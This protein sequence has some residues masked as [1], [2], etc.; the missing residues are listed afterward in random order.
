MSEDYEIPENLY[1]TK[2][3]EWAR[4][5]DNVVVMGITDYAQTQL[6]EVVY[7]E[8][9]E[10]GSEVEQMEAIG[11]VESVK[12]VSEIYTPVSGRIIEVNRTLEDRPELVNVDPY[13]EGWIAKIQPTNLKEELKSLM[14][15][16]EYADYLRTLE[17]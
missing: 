2:E 6:H 1:Y 15:A 5:E 3:H 9:P 11:T 13:G 17:E 12:A 10:V 8:L 7:V 4:V 14:T 16:A